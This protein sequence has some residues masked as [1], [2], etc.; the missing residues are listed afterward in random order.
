MTIPQ[1]QPDTRS[2]GAV[3][4]PLSAGDAAALAE[5]ARELGA[6][7]NSAAAP[8]LAGVYA[9]LLAAE[10][11]KFRGVVVAADT[12]GL[13]AGLTGLAE[14]RSAD[15]LFVGPGPVSAGAGPVFVF[16]GQGSQWPGMALELY[17]TSLAFRASLD[18]SAEQLGRW[19]DWD[20]LEVLRAPGAPDLAQVDV[21]Q[22]VLFAVMVALAAVWKSF[23]VQ[24]AAVI[25]H[26]QG[27]IAAAHLA[28][29]LS[30]ADAARVVVMRSRVL[31]RLTGL[32]GMLSV[33]MPSE[34]AAAYVAERSDKL[35]VAA[36]NG[37]GSVVVSG[38]VE[39]LKLLIDRCA[40]EGV[41]AR[42]VKVD[43][44]SHSPQ[45]EQVRAELLELIGDVDAGKGEVP[46]YSAVQGELLDGTELV[47]DYWYRNLRRT[48]QFSTTVRAALAAGHRQ[49]IEVSPHPVVAHGLR[50]TL[51]H[52]EDTAVIG[53]VQRGEGGMD[54]FLCSV[55]AAWTQG[56]DVRWPGGPQR[57]SS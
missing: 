19:T 53:S 29:V 35:S 44:P 22:P 7:L 47:A 2:T 43:Y 31:R 12:A 50:L 37:P 16:P 20:L 55:A 9:E 41:R 8:D 6:R 26:S 57:L 5:Q 40:E 17:D 24:P 18:A 27:E 45:V 36:E 54:R 13:L 51:K 23:D 39:E 30:L 42:M 21:V 52:D 11:G 46:Y 4:Y 33:P 28:G 49:F 3:A 14:G 1:T 38:E 56:A 32:G 48:V 10:V 34:W 25:G 15:G